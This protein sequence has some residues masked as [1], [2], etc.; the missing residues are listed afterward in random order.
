MKHYL[1][2]VALFALI[3]LSS[4]SLPSD[5]AEP[6]TYPDIAAYVTTYIV[7]DLENEGEEV[8]IFETDGGQKLFL[9]DNC[10]TGEYEFEDLE[11][12]VIYFAVIEDY[13]VEEF[14]QSAGTA[15]D[16]EYGLRLFNI[17]QV[18]TSQTVT[19]ETEEQ[20]D[21][22]ADHAISYIYDSIYLSNGYIN[23]VA[24]LRA[25]KLSDVNI[26]LVENLAVEPEKSEEGYLNLELRYDRGSDEAIG[27][28]YEK[29]VSLSLEQFE[30]QIEEADGVM[31]RAKTLKGGTIHI[32]L[33]N[34]SESSRAAVATR[35]NT[36]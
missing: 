35:T 24:G 19:V 15:Y 16:C 20:S 26:Y 22:I 23:M 34:K 7:E 9:A 8:Y 4:C 10:L 17:V 3:S 1:F 6:G 29:Y 27:S 13:E 30:E 2:S 14:A 32:K 31:L 5:A 12:L 11:R 28:T 25:D 18:L 21:Q 36:L 33:D